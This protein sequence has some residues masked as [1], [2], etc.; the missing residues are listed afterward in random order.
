[1]FID[2]G[3][4]AKMS[5]SELQALLHA[6]SVSSIELTVEQDPTLNAYRMTW[7]VGAIP[8]NENALYERLFDHDK[9]LPEE[10]YD[11]VT[12]QNVLMAIGRRNLS[13]RDHLA[14]TKPEI[15]GISASSVIMDELYMINE[16]TFRRVTEPILG[17]YTQSSSL[18][19][20][21]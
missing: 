1:M 10:S 16:K 20:G 18:K 15:A 21:K 2:Y 3:D 8:R 19:R 9:F 5:G 7:T 17:S 12:A 6:R 14:L 4:L 13:I 11:L